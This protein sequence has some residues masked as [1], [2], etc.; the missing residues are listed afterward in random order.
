MTL[1]ISIKQF[2]EKSE[3][4]T[5]FFPFSGSWI[6]IISMSFMLMVMMTMMG[7][8]V[9]RI[10]P[11]FIRDISSRRPLNDFVKFSFVKPNSTAFRTAID[12]N[13]LALSDQKVNAFAFRAFHQTLL[14]CFIN[15]IT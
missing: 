15:S 9:S 8:H 10:T 1:I 2:A 14:L 7:F 11:I 5:M 6:Y 4:A 3:R 12:F 13:S